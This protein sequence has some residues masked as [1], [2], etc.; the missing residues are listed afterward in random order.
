MEDV[1]RVVS[2]YVKTDSL[3]S[4]RK[5]ELIPPRLQVTAVLLACH[6]TDRMLSAT[7]IARVTD[8]SVGEAYPEL[9][10]LEQRGVA[11]RTADGDYSINSERIDYAIDVLDSV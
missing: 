5:C 8:C 2:Q 3:R 11:H 4:T 1:E 7:E 6:L 10:E 9:R